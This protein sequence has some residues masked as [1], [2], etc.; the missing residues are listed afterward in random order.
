NQGISALTLTPDG[1]FAAFND[2]R[3][4]FDNQRR[5]AIA[6]EG[7]K[8]LQEL[9]PSWNSLYGI[10]YIYD[11]L[12]NKYVLRIDDQDDSRIGLNQL[13]FRPDG[14]RLAGA[15]PISKSVA[16]WDSNTGKRLIRFRPGGDHVENL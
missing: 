8:D 11:R 16:I 15:S 14:K 4:S 6:Q 2:W 5:L 12:A 7:A 10:L 13:A 3:N 1:N 9:D